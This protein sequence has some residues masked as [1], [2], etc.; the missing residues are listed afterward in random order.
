[1]IEYYKNLSLENLP[2]INEEGL[3]CWE[4]FRDIPEYEGFYQVSDLGRVKSLNRIIFRESDKA[5]LNKK[6]RILKSN[7]DISGYP[8]V[9]LYINNS[10]KFC[11]VH[12]LVMSTFIGKSDKYI[13]HKDDIRYNNILS[14]L[15]YCTQRENNTVYKKI[16]GKS[17]YMGVYLAKRGRWIAGI[18]IDGVYYNLGAYDIE[19]LASNEYNKAL[20]NWENNKVLP[21]YRSRLKTSKYKYVGKRNKKWEAKYKNKVIGTY[22]TEEEAY[23]AVINHI[24]NVQN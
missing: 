7:I 14:N 11:K 16:R 19:E 6:E 3:V 18:T 22:L 20:Y 5:Y 2:Y 21:N 1:M 12:R 4:E 9:N 23:E 15:R 13:D 8:S 10:K 24:K 17:K